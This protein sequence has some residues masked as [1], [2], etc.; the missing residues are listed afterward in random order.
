MVLGSL[1]VYAV[2]VPYLADCA[3]L[4]A[5]QAVR[6]GL[7]PYLLISSA[8]RS[9]RRWRWRRFPPRGAWQGDTA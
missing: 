4:S 1:I 6:L 8:T 9:R 3:H 2:G 7:R 5:A